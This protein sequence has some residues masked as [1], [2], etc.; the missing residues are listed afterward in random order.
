MFKVDFAGKETVEVIAP[1]RTHTHTHTKHIS[2]SIANLTASWYFIKIKYS[3]PNISTPASVSP[4]AFAVLL[5]AV[6][7][8]RCI[9]AG[10]PFWIGGELPVFVVRPHAPNRDACTVTVRYEYMYCATPNKHDPEWEDAV[11]HY[12]RYIQC[13]RQRGITSVVFWDA[14]MNIGVAIISSHLSRGHCG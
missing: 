14:L 9:A 3:E 5:L 7:K 13:H 12:W 4:L 1:E 8:Q 10:A 11:R 6:I 2:S